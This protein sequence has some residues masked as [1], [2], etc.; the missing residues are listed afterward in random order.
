MKATK[1]PLI[2]IGAGPACHGQVLVLHDVLGLSDRPPAFAK[3]LANLGEQ[4][5]QAGREWVEIVASRGAG[6][7]PYSKKS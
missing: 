2:G 4:I 6:P 5:R 3:P 1:V 7:S